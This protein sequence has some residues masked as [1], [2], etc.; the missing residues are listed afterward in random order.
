L[1]DPFLI[2]DRRTR[3]PAGPE[4]PGLCM[5]LHDPPHVFFYHRFRSESERDGF[6]TCLGKAVS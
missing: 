2:I 3:C 1:T 5:R 6:W 4:R